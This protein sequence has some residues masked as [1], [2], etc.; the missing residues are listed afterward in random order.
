MGIPET[1]GGSSSCEVLLQ[2]VVPTLGALAAGFLCISPWP[3]VKAAVKNGETGDLNSLPFAVMAG[4]A[5]VWTVYSYYIRDYFLL[6]PNTF[7]FACGLYYSLVLLP[8]SASKVQNQITLTLVGLTTF[9]I[10][11][12]GL[13]FI[14]Q[15]ESSNLI[16]GIITNVVLVGFYGSPLSVCLKVIKT[17]DTSSLSVP[18]LITTAVNFFIA[19]PQ[20]L[21]IL[22]VLIQ[23]VLLFVFRGEKAVSESDSFGHESS[24]MATEIED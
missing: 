21:G 5:L 3:Q 12:M 7:G 24:E 22:F 20:I 16:M 10:F 23:A 13:V 9:V 18:L 14:S 6:F 15:V 1:C 8:I 19:V 11:S 17:R 2:Y 4:N